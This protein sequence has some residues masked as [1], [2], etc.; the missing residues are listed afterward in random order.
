[1]KGLLEF[2]YVYAH[3]HEQLLVAIACESLYLFINIQ[4][5]RCTP[6]IYETL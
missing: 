6:P 5:Y 1:M 2:A 3:Y 4:E